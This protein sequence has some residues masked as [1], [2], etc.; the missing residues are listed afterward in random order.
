MLCQFLF[1]LES[2]MIVACQWTNQKRRGRL[3]SPLPRRVLFPSA[4]TAAVRLSGVSYAGKTIGSSR[5]SSI[6]FL[7]WR[8]VGICGMPTERSVVFLHFEDFSEKVLKNQKENESYGEDN[9]E[10]ARQC[11]QI[12]D[13]FHLIHISCV[14]ILLSLSYMHS[15]FQ[16]GQAVP[17]TNFS[18]KNTP[19]RTQA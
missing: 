2:N 15:T 3:W 7:G 13:N 6:R 11:K 5:I 4:E 10:E 12:R 9:A 16:C 17:T 18:R 14:P 1:A 19:E 8:I